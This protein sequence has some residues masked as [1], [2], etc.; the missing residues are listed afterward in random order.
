M[1]EYIGDSKTSSYSVDGTEADHFSIAIQKCIVTH[2]GISIFKNV[3]FKNPIVLS[4]FCDKLGLTMSLLSLI[5]ILM[6]I[7]YFASLDQSM[8]VFP[9][10]LESILISFEKLVFI[11]NYENFL[12]LKF[13]S[14]LDTAHKL[15]EAIKK[16]H[17]WKYDE[18]NKS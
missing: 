10:K 15:I 18:K 12:M 3:P 11:Q 8:V 6:M 16:I 14:H 7:F 9:V 1:I 5:L 4:P 17:E 2:S 13:S